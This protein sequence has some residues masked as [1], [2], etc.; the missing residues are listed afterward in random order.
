[1]A[2]ESKTVLNQLLRRWPRGTVAL[3]SW[4]KTQGVSSQLLYHYRHSNWIEAVGKG[5]F[6]RTGD[7]VDFRGAVYALQ[8]HAQLEIHPGGKTALKLH[9][10]AH[11]LELSTK[12][13]FLW[14][15]ERVPLP[16]WIKAH[17]WG[18][19]LSYMATS[20]LPPSLALS[21]M[22]CGDFSIKLSSPERALLELLYMSPKHHGLVE[23]FEILEGSNTL[24][25]NIV[26]QLLEACKSVK[27]KRL[28]LFLSKKTEHDWF[29]YLDPSRVDL[30]SGK[31][32]IEKG[33]SYDSEFQIVLPRELSIHGDQDLH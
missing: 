33:G 21:E 27:V 16:R 25:P 6:V 32:T 30:G 17:D 12:R 24:R 10:K 29:H 13:E 31:R 11:Y 26:Q 18:V 15:P 20:F 28:F 4:L 9:G 8:K 14:G 22:D 7:S 5:A 3:T 19:D 23:C 1:M 2:L